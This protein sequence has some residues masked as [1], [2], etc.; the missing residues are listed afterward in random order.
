M[1]R[2]LYETTGMQLGG[3]M[4]EAMRRIEAGEDPD[5]V[6]EEMGDLLE[7]EGPLP[8]EGKSTFRQMSR[9]M[10]PPSVDQTLYDL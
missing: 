9:R 8:E 3:N 7:E 1:M 2:K 4:E 6:E 5:K 10:K